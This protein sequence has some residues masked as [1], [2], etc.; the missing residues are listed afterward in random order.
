MFCRKVGKNAF[1][2]FARNY[3]AISMLSVG[4]L[5]LLLPSGYSIGF[6]LICFA[7]F[8]I[9]LKLGG[10]LLSVEAKYLILPLIIYSIGNV[11]LALNERWAFR[12]FGNYL[13]FVLV[14]FGLWGIRTYKP[15]PN[16]FWLGLALGALGAAIFS[17]YQAKVLGQRAGGFML[18]IQFGNISLLLA[19][20]CMVRALAVPSLSM[21]SGLLW[22]GFIGGLAASVW[23]QTRGGWVALVLVLIWIF[24]NATKSWAPIKKRITFIV[25]CLFFMVPVFQP[26]GVVQSRVAE[27]ITDVSAYLET[28]KQD[29]SVGARFA[30]WTLASRSLASAPISGH[31]DKG[32]IELRDS[33]ISDGRLSSFSSKFTHVHNEFLNV[34]FKRGFIGLALYLAMF[35]VPMLLFFRP[36]LHHV[37]VEVRSLAMAGMVIPMMYMDFGLTQTFLSHNSGRIVLCSL[38]MC[39]AGLMLNAVEDNQTHEAS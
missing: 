23:S 37:S 24:V 29:S 19:V 25:F 33:A 36:Y 16:W 38:W 28:G 2:M 9:W 30:M 13:P 12:E 6:Y 26:N 17:A 10:D 22:L 14:I 35:L 1:L 32:W 8:A 21:F 3:F 7:S 18:A 5:A 4:G 31:G 20:L 39:V 34:A 27:A 11:V 15:H